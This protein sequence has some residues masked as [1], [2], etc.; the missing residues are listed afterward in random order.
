MFPSLDQIYGY[1]ETKAI[2]SSAVAAVLAA[3]IVAM[4]SSA[5]IVSAFPVGIGVFI[6]MPWG[7]IGWRHLQ[8]LKYR[9]ID[10]QKWDRVNLPTLWQAACM[11][12]DIEPYASLRDGTPCYAN[13]QMLKSE[14]M[15]G[16]L[17][18]V[19]EYGRS[20]MSQRVRREDL[21]SLAERRGDR[22]KSLFPEDR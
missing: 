10:L 5:S 7:F 6:L 13:L 8:S 18:I 19:G 2:V 15:A 1:I 21:R 9:P 22:P 11:Y 12:D 14:I 16:T 3:A 4:F 17:E 20:N